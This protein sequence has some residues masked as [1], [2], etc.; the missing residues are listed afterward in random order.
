MREDRP[1]ERQQNNAKRSESRSPPRKGEQHT[2]VAKR[3]R[4]KLTTWDLYT[5]S[6][7]SPKKK[8][9]IIERYQ[10]SQRREGFEKDDSARNDSVSDS[11]RSDSTRSESTS[12]ESTS[13]ENTSSENT[14]SY[15]TARTH[16]ERCGRE[17]GLHTEFK[18]PER[19]ERSPPISEDSSVISMASMIY[20]SYEVRIQI[21]LQCLKAIRY[22]TNKINPSSTI[23]K[24]P[25]LVLSHDLPK[26]PHEPPG[27][28]TFTNRSKAPKSHESSWTLGTQS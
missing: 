28:Q 22:Q 10:G 24:K 21:I 5:L 6:I 14:S 3:P 27:T 23:P 12:S 13:S 25:T 8:R 26:E 9:E 2:D 17:S 15:K 11:L 19:L 20:G 7:R 4:P 16:P 18:I 1:R